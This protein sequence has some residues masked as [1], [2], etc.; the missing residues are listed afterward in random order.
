MYHDVLLCLITTLKIS[1]SLGMYSNVIEFNKCTATPLW[2]AQD[3]WRQSLAVAQ[4]RRS[5]AVERES[6]R[7]VQVWG[8]DLV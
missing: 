8:Q 6:K 4:G 5:I 2:W 1:A 3:E 7:S